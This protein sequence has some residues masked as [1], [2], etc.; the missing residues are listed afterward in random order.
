LFLSEAIQFEFRP[1]PVRDALA[2]AVAQQI[3]AL[4]AAIQHAQETG[5]LSGEKDA[6]RVASE[7]HS[8]LVNADA[9]FS[10]TGDRAVYEQSRASI[11]EVLGAVVS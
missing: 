10:V 3:E 11:R 9:L 7:L 1:G 4:R 6:S 8:L 2:S 5:E